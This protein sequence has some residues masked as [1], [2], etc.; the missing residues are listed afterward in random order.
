MIK[1][2][3]ISNQTEYNKKYIIDNLIALTEY[4]SENKRKKIDDELLNNNSNNK[5][6]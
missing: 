3:A 4:N 1:F 5:N 6:L 2:I